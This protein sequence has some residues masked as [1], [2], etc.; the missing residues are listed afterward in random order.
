MKLLHVVENVMM[1]LSGIPGLDFLRRYVHD[2][3]SF[4]SEQFRK[5][6]EYKGYVRAAR[7]AGKDVAQAARGEKR[8]EPVD[9]DEY[10]E[11]ED[12]DLESYGY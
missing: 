9:D 11:E 12:D 7:D 3:Q 2:Y 8:E 5:V 6:D 4:R 1:K 10:V